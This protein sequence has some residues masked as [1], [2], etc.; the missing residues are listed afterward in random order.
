MQCP[1]CG[2]ENE[3]N[4]VVCRSCGHALAFDE[5]ANIAHL[6]L[7]SE[8]GPLQSITLTG[9]MTIGRT[10]GN[11][12]VIPDSALSRQ[13]ARVEVSADGISVVDLGSLNGVFVNDMRVEDVR[14]LRNGD[15]IRVGRTTLTASLPEPPPP[16][17]TGT[18]KMAVGSS[19]EQ[20]E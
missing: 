11:D 8:G 18:V 10:A 19:V 15:I 5:A 20:E 12:I 14:E 13:H 17:E 6:L 3:T 1:S 2:T 16:P 9:S 7:E 4:S